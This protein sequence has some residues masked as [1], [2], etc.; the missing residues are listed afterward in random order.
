MAKSTS[1]LLQRFELD[2]LSKLLSMF[3]RQSRLC[4]GTTAVLELRLPR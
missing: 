4:S 2:L 1:D 3:R